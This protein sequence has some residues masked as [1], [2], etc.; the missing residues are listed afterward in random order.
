MHWRLTVIL[1]FSIAIS[2]CGPGWDGYQDDY[3]EDFHNEGE[4]WAGDQIVLLEINKSVIEATLSEMTTADFLGA[5][6]ISL[7]ELVL[8][9]GLTQDPEL[10][11]YDFTATDGYNLLHKRYDDPTLL[12]TWKEME[13]GYL[14]LDARN[15]DLT[16]GWEAHPWGNALSAYQVKYMNGGTITLLPI[17]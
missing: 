10:F 2:A 6:S 8:S 13:A 15:D 4:P 5:P 1:L 17:E 14:Y 9:S 16:C 12:P 11:R 3:S 7:A